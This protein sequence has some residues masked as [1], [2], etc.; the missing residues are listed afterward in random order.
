MLESVN[1]SVKEYVNVQA[2]TNGIES[3]WVLLKRGYYGTHHKMSAKH[4][5]RYIDECAGWHD[6]REQDTVD[7]WP[8]L[9]KALLGNGYGIK[10]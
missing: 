2:H 4:L 10:N 8:S 9:P 1:H 5:R 3:F 6:I 7:K